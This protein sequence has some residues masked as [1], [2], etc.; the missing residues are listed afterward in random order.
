[1]IRILFLLI[2]S[3]SCKG[4]ENIVDTKS[5]IKELKAATKGNWKYKADCNCYDG[6]STLYEKINSSKQCILTCTT[7]DLKEILG[8][9][10][11]QSEGVY[12]YRLFP[13]EPGKCVSYEFYFNSLMQLTNFTTSVQTISTEE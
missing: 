13:C 12:R 5:C 3:L 10:T 6:T 7:E 2:F 11:G 1:M 8:A 9:P 4:S